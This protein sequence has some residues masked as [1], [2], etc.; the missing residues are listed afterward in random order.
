MKTK[1]IEEYRENITLH[2]TR[3]SGDVEHIKEKVDLTNNHLEKINGRLRKAE[4][5][6]TAIKT[7]GSTLTIVLGSLL[8][9]IGIDK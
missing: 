1:S 5:N 6:I 7:I 3:I 8:T 4:N 9:W 2:L